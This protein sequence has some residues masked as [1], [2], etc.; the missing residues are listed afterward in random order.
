MATEKQALYRYNNW[1]SFVNKWQDLSGNGYRLVDVETD[2]QSNGKTYF[3]G[4]WQE[5]DGKYA[6][7]RYNNW[8]SFTDKWQDLSGN[9]Y[10]LV[11]VETD[12]QSNGK[13]YFTGVWREGDGKHALYRYDNWG[14]FTDKWQDLSGKGYRLVDFNTDVQSNGKTYFTGVWQEGDGKY[15][16]YRYNNWGSFT[17]KWQD[18]SGKGYRLVDVETDIQSNGK[19]YFTGVWQE[20]DGQHALYRYN[21]W[22]SFTNKWQDLSSQGYTLADVETDIQSNGKTY[23][24][25]TWYKA[26]HQFDD[27]T[28]ISSTSTNFR[29]QALAGDHESD[30]LTNNQGGNDTEFDEISKAFLGESPIESQEGL[31]TDLVPGDEL[32]LLNATATD[33]NGNFTPDPGVEQSLE[34]E[35]G[36]F[37]ETLNAASNLNVLV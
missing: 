23:F 14:S 31:L 5:G 13:T 8:G 18:L 37:A 9:G 17:D 1:G 35:F 22:N 3:T 26:D 20:G 7:Y 16:L 32:L 15:A 28:G 36:Q 12:I 27:I 30:A 24:T 29:S 4:T 34:A 6:L 10:R 33:G 2:I 11:D 25:G 19:T 21:N